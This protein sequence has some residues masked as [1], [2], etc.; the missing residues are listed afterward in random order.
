MLLS[1]V[2]DSESDS[3]FIIVVTYFQKMELRTGRFF[4]AGAELVVISASFFD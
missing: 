1:I 3:K 2:F 4:S